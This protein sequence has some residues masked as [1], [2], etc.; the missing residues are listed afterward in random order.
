MQINSILEFKLQVAITVYIHVQL[1]FQQEGQHSTLNH[2]Q[3]PNRLQVLAHVVLDHRQTSI[4]QKFKE[5]I[6]LF[7]Q[8]V[9][10]RLYLIPWHHLLFHR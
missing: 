3:L 7:S 6:V 5:L 1:E 10:Q 9:I 4:Y 2:N 8:V